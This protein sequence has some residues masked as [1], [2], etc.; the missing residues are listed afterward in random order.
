MKRNTIVKTFLLL[1]ILFFVTNL[2]D[3]ADCGGNVTCACGDTL[4]A[5]YDM[6]QDL[7]N[8]S[9][10]LLINGLDITLDCRD[11]SII[12]INS[13]YAIY[14]SYYGGSLNVYNCNIQNFS[15]G[16]S[17]IGGANVKNNT[18]SNVNSAIFIKRSYGAGI[19]NN[20]ITNVNSNAIELSGEQPLFQIFYS[21][22]NYIKNNK[23]SDSN[24]GIV[25]S[26]FTSHNA[27]FENEIFNVSTGIILYGN[28]NLGDNSY[29][30]IKEN[31]IHGGGIGISLTALYLTGGNQI[32]NNVFLDNSQNS[33]ITGGAYTNYYDN[34]SVG[35]YWSD[36]KANNCYP[37][38]YCLNSYENDSYPLYEL[39]DW[40][41]ISLPPIGPTCFDG[42]M[43]QDEAGIDCGGVC[44]Y[45]CDGC[46]PLIENG[47]HDDKIDIVFVPNEDYFNDD[48]L[49]TSLFLDNINNLIDNSFNVTPLS[50][51]STIIK[52][53]LGKF[54]FY[55]IEKKGFLNP[56]I[57]T[58]LNFLWDCSFS[59]SAVIVH[60]NEAKDS[61]LPK[62]YSTEYDSVGTNLHELGHAFF[63]LADE[64]SGYTTYFYPFPFPNIWP[65]NSSCSGDAISEEWDPNL[66]NQFCLPGKDACGTSG[67]W[68]LNEY[69]TIMQSIYNNRYE[70]DPWGL[71]SIRR[72]EWILD[73]YPGVAKSGEG[74]NEVPSTKNKVAL[75]KL[76]FNEERIYLNGIQIV[77]NEAPDE[78]YGNGINLT[79]LRDNTT[80]YNSQFGN[81][82]IVLTENESV[83][84]NES[85]MTL[86]V[87]FTL[88]ETSIKIYNETG[89]LQLTI[90][91]IPYIKQFC[92]NWDGTCDLDC[93]IDVDPDCRLEINDFSQVYKENTTTIFQFIIK[94][95]Y[96]ETISGINWTLNIGESNI[97]SI[98]S[99]NLS[100]GEEIYGFV[101]YNYSSNGYYNTTIKAFNR[102]Y[103][104]TKRLEVAI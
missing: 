23:I 72:I 32:W 57:R 95:N 74:I 50:N 55:Y 2:V 20:I 17:I 40:I 35:N 28:Q 69:Q 103:V 1:F 8:C 47:N 19:E 5:D 13:G 98:Q 6:T 38:K 91:T 15:S 66:C 99:M 16:I 52:D 96:E 64:Y 90:N 73:K 29:N 36:F 53:S 9:N 51:G 82:R 71:A 49:N 65:S 101:E 80:L 7:I 41:N 59:D 44:P 85:N 81:P 22:Y 77:Y 92:T 31:Y 102:Y 94:N 39:P 10:G 30:L 87:P 58:P 54:N 4:V 63:G 56:G 76:L 93:G 24:K 86:V 42:V 45:S 48:V 26:K 21:S 62:I 34:G 84:L 43:N 14:D 25:F 79:V 104:D 78:G 12:G 61:A 100:S 70:V 46:I 75:L 27:A 60:I 11:H 89:D 68:R 37:D 83:Y 97:T 18:V 3:A 67:W 33:Y 88:N